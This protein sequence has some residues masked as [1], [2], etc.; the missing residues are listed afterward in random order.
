MAS[1]V[2][3]WILSG[4]DPLSSLYSK[5]TRSLKPARPVGRSDFGSWLLAGV[6]LPT[7]AFDSRPT[8]HYSAA[9]K[10]FSLLLFLEDF[11]VAAPF[12]L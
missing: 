3:A 1:T 4:L 8:T 11:L 7:I 10:S 6:P 12:L 2:H 9:L 5:S